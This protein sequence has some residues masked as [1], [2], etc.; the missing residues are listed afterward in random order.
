MCECVCEEVWG[1]EEEGVNIQTKD[2]C[3]LACFFPHHL[4]SERYISVS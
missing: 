4:L 1:D 3:L 2:L